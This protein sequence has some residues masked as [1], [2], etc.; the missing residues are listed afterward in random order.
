MVEQKQLRS[1]LSLY[2]A[3]FSSGDTLL[4]SFPGLFICLIISKT[5]LCS[6]FISGNSDFSLVQ[7][8]LKLLSERFSETALCE[9]TKVTARS[10]RPM[11]ML[12]G[13]CQILFVGGC[14]H[15]VKYDIPSMAATE[16]VLTKLLF[17]AHIQTT[18]FDT[19]PQ[20]PC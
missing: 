18:G 13:S 16:H 14:K 15:R 6:I 11:I 12:P 4:L 8:Y 5:H 20:A 9:V 1:L 2:S 3:Q 17:I 7:R 10:P 19:C